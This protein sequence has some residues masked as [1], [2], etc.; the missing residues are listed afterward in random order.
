[1]TTKISRVFSGFAAGRWKPATGAA[2]ALLL[3]LTA[4]APPAAGTPAVG[5]VYS[6]QLVNGYNK[7]VRGKVQYQVEQVGADRI[8]VSVSPDNAEAGWAHS[9]TYTNEGNWLRNL[10]ESHGVPVEYVFAT[11]YPAYVFPLEPGKSWSV[12]VKATVPSLGARRSVR[13]DAWVIGNE[14]IRVPAGEFDTIKIRRAVYPGDSNFARMET[15]I[16][17][18]DWYAP[19]LGRAVRTERRSTWLDLSQCGKDGMCDFRGDWNI[20]ELLE[21]PAARK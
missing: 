17:E 20:Y 2:T 3:V 11:A 7:E 18:L 21:A 5:D 16:T 13:V 15:Q 12:R 8:T 9:E 19:A 6:Y 14:R 4:L 10:V 1:M